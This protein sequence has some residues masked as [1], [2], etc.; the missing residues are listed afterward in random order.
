[1]KSK[2]GTQLELQ[3]KTP[4][5]Y[6]KEQMYLFGEKVSPDERMQAID[7]AQDE[8]EQLK[9]SDDFKAND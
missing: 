4:V 7:E 1:M 2:T 5:F 3:F 8:A 6:V 9:Q